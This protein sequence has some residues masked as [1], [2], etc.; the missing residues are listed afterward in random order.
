MPVV[1]QAIQAKTVGYL[2][3]M[4]QGAV[5]RTARRNATVLNKFEVSFRLKRWHADRGG[6]AQFYMPEPLS[7]GLHW[8]RPV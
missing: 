8:M 2:Q 7:H 6:R 1:V 3:T 5:P 4:Q